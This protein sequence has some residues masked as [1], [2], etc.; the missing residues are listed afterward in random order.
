V[1]VLFP[2][3]SVPATEKSTTTDWLGTGV[4]SCRWTTPRD[5]SEGTAKII[6]EE[7]QKLLRDADERA[8]Q[9][10]EGHRKELDAIVE[11]LLQREELLREEIELVLK[12]EK[13]PD[14]PKIVEPPP[15]KPPREPASQPEAPPTF[16]PA[17]SPA[18]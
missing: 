9:L 1:D 11:A 17:P 10:L 3:E 8:Y 18:V 4:S 15:P 7:V 2:D 5:F 12:G 13:L 16:K 6:D 14:L